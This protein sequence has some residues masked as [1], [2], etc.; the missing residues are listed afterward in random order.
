L[1]VFDPEIVGLQWT[2]VLESVSLDPYGAGAARAYEAEGQAGLRLYLERIVVRED[3]HLHL[4]DASGKDLTG[5]PLRRGVQEFARHPIEGREVRAKVSFGQTLVASSVTGP[6]GT[7]YRVVLAIPRHE[8]SVM[9]VFGQGWIWGAL[10]A[11]LV[12]SAVCYGIARALTSPVIR[13]CE[14]ARSLADGD[15]SARVSNPQI[16]ERHDEFSQLGRDFN[17]MASRIELLVNAKQRLLWDISH[18]LRSP[19]T[20][21]SLALAMARR[22]ANPEAAPAMDRIEREAENLNRLIEQLL[23]LARITGGTG[24][25]LAEEI[26]LEALVTSIADDAA[27]EASGVSRSVRLEVKGAGTVAGASELL[28]SAIENVVRN[29]VR[30]TAE[31]TAV[32]ILVEPQR[33][34]KAILIHVRDHGP[35]VPEPELDR[36]FEVFYR[37]P[38]TRDSTA[39]SGLGLAIANQAVLAHGGWVKAFNAEGGGLEVQIGLPVKDSGSHPV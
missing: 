35:G 3:V 9:P 27:F 10:A 33:D 13:V 21:L 23:T 1:Q 4:F 18:E 22:K 26:D 8:G 17:A 29:A 5:F 20:R 19:L 25:S 36:L 37:V 32:S 38:E 14:A 15:L 7:H 31:G 2:P 16:L 30:Y 39:G 11:L 28:R 24:P 12:L 34:G 6:S